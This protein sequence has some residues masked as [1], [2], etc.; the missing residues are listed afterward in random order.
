MVE[1]AEHHLVKR[2][3]YEAAVSMGQHAQ[4]EAVEESRRFDVLIGVHH[5]L[6]LEV[7]VTP[8]S[9]VR[10]SLRTSASDTL[11]IWLYRKGLYASA[12]EDSFEYELREGELYVAGVPCADFLRQVTSM[13]YHG[14]PRYKRYET[15]GEEW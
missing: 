8:Q 1:S 15:L 12:P 14:G 13:L 5:Q 6:A 11:Q 3:V 7:Q 2:L 10:E 4:V 9:R